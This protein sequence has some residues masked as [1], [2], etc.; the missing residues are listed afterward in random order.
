MPKLKRVSR[1]DN[2]PLTAAYFTPEG[3]LR[4]K[5][6]V[7]TCG[8][9]EY[10]NDDGS[11]RRE[12]RLPENVFAPESLRT[13]RGKPIIF[14]HEAGEITKDNVHEEIIGT[15]LSDGLKD[16]DNVRADIVIH[17]TDCLKQGLRELSL[18][19]DCELDESPGTY[20]GMPYDAIQRNIIINHLAIVE[21]A[22]AGHEARLNLDSKSG[23]GGKAKMKKRKRRDGLAETLTPEQLEAAAAM[24]L[25]AS[26][27]TNTDDD[28]GNDDPVERV[29]QNA[30]RRD[31]DISAV[32]EEEIPAM[33]EDIKT[34]LDVIDAMKDGD[35]TNT[36]D[37]DD[38]DNQDD[39][40]PDNTDGD[41][42]PDNQDDD[43]E[44][45]STNTDDDDD[46]D[47]QDDDDD[48]DNTDGD[49]TQ[50]PKD[51]KSLTMDSIENRF[52]EMYSIAQMA[53][54]L[55]LSG[56]VPRNVMEGKKRIIKAMNPKLK[57]DG[58]SRAYINGVYDSTVQ[59]AK[60]RKTAVE[61]A[62][63]LVGTGNRSRM[64]SSSESNASL[65]RKKMIG[66]LTNRK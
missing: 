20:K 5:P 39:D 24:Y 52:A 61:K 31:E 47:N 43:D 59:A 11:I 54:R 32:G 33:Q 1:L 53:N 10:Q 37:D 2:I 36:D 17:D 42:D 44:P 38:P 63:K 8:I 12:L 45:D 48:P 30:D 9:F 18:G 60:T 35:G 41:D 21:A 51:D 29:R 49:E 27:D 6:I 26:Q 46:P 58:K 3:Y 7:T 4:D 23:K 16:G 55:G 66:G 28:E 62:R 34:L 64:D 56:F 40:D 65:A 25:A 15:V 57:L 19:Y 13:Y 50:D 14:T 22:R